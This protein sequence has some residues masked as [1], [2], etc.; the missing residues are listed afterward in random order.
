[1]ISDVVPDWL[2]SVPLPPDV[3]SK[4][5]GEVTGRLAAAEEERGL[6][7]SERDLLQRRSHALAERAESLA[8]DRTMMQHA[9]STAE[10]ARQEAERTA[11]GL[12]EQV[13]RLTMALTAA[14]ED[15]AAARAREHMLA[16]RLRSRKALPDA[17]EY[18]RLRPDPLGAQTAAELIEALR[19]F[20]TW[21]G[22]P[23]YRNMALRSGRRAG[24][25]TMCTLLSGSDLPARLEMIDA[26]VEG[27]GGTDEDRQKF[28]T[29]W[30]KLTMP[31]ALPSEPPSAAELRLRVLPAGGEA[32]APA[33]QSA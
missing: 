22:N 20:R 9:M 31:D 16:D 32:H 24:A 33:A 18:Q 25:S 30:R 4:L 11:A 23:S 10:T 19:Q 8:N 1:M 12:R 13:S 5:V 27:C 21:A 7:R 15:V 17:G 28:A 14:R 2:A 26:I 29:A 6:L 3:M